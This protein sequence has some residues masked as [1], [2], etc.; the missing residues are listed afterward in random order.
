[1]QVL[2]YANRTMQW[3]GEHSMVAHVRQLF[4]HEQPTVVCVARCL[5]WKLECIRKGVVPLLTTLTVWGAVMH[6]SAAFSGAP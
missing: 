4:L 2:C 5:N 6:L 3:A 1:M